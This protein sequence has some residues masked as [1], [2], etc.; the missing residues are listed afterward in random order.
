MGHLRRKWLIS[1]PRGP[2]WRRKAE[3]PRRGSPVQGL[4]SRFC[5][6]FVTWHTHVE[7]DL[8]VTPIPWLTKKLVF[9]AMFLTLY[10]QQQTVQPLS[11]FPTFYISGPP[12]QQVQYLQIRFD[13][14]ADPR[15]WTSG[16]SQ[17]QPEGL[18]RPGEIMCSQPQIWLSAEIGIHDFP[19][20]DSL[21]IPRVHCSFEIC[22][23]FFRWKETIASTIWQNPLSLSS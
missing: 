1:L 23:L 4:G 19:G 7:W 20:M 14:C 9:C 6:S 12:Y 16:T 11:G 2:S 17:T 8:P 15:G 3:W 10:F 5:E 18:L 22:F 21:P 13:A